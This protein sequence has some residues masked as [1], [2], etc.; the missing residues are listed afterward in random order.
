MPDHPN[1]LP[2]T[3]KRV[4]LAADHVLSFLLEDN[5]LVKDK[6]SMVASDLHE[7]EVS[8]CPTLRH[9]REQ[10]VRHFCGATTLCP[11]F[12]Y[13]ALVGDVLNGGHVATGAQNLDLKEEGAFTGEVSPTMLLDAGLQTCDSGTQRAPA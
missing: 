2:K 1:I 6:S 9:I 12:P 10:P 11:A 4:G 7:R 13:S 8:L 5:A 3:P